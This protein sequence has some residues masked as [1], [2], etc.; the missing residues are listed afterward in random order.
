VEADYAAT[1]I[2]RTREVIRPSLM[3][4]TLTYVIWHDSPNIHLSGAACTPLIGN[5]PCPSDQCG[6][7]DTDK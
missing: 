6:T 1:S 2:V 4:P 3:S 7:D 5:K